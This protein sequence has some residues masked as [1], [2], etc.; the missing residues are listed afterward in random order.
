MGY[1]FGIGF[2]VLYMGL[3]LDF[4]NIGL[5][6]IADI[7]GPCGP[8]MDFPPEIYGPCGP[9]MIFPPEIMDIEVHI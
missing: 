8:H 5:A 7:C 3:R 9:Y 2:L 4:W 1:R 6:L